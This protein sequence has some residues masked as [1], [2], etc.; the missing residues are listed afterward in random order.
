M[1]AQS[2][3]LQCFRVGLAINQDKVRSDVAI[4]MVFP[5]AGQ[6]MVTMFLGE[7]EIVSQIG[8][9]WPRKLP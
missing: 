1:R 6:G 3:E 7:R 5:V 8:R 9:Q 4:A 2:N